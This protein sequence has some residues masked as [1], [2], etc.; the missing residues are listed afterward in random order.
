MNNLVLNIGQYQLNLLVSNH[1]GEDYIALKPLCEAL[2]LSWPRQTKRTQG[3]PQFRCCLKAIPSAGGM[4]D[5]LCLPV[6]QIGMW[7][8]TINANRVN[9]ESRPKLLAF[10]EQLQVVIHDHLTGKL[11]MERLQSLEQSVKILSEVVARLEF[12]IHDLRTE[13]AELRAQLRATS[14]LDKTLV[15]NAGRHLAAHKKA[16]KSIN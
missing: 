5:M 2:G 11:S 3:N 15:S 13:N 12:K 7:L 16:Q 8:C 10:Q 4:Q 14:I 9:D 1:G 6:L